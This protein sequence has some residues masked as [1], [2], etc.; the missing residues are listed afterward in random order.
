MSFTCVATH[1]AARKTQARFAAALR[2]K[3]ALGTV[4][5]DH[6]KCSWNVNSQCRHHLSPR[7][8]ELHAPQWQR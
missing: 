4:P 6:S 8:H 2:G 7:A 5:P 3:R 1:A